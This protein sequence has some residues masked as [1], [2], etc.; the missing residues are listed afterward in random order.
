MTPS[1]HFPFTI[2]HLPLISHFSFAVDIQSTVCE[3][4][5]VKSLKIENC[6]LINASEGG[7]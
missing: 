2:F 4:E 5:N 6:E 3:M 7:V 1:F